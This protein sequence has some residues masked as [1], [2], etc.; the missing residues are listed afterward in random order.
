MRA[1]WTHV[2]PVP[3]E[4]GAYCKEAEW[5]RMSRVSR[6]HGLEVIIRSNRSNIIP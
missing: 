4:N 3:L 6:V 5:V 2:V 1:I